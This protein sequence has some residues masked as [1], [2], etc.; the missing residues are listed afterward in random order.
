[1]I[2]PLI[3]SCCV[4]RR[5][6]LRLAAGDEHQPVRAHVPGPLARLLRQADH[7][8]GRQHA[9]N[10]AGSL[11][12][13]IQCVDNTIQYF[14]AGEHDTAGARRWQDHQPERARQALQHRAMLP[15]GRVRLHPEPASRL[16][17]RCARPGLCALR[18]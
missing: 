6:L 16:G 1:M 2:S 8:H 5:V 4:L 15:R 13:P 17:P 14:H 7:A 9:Q 12:F 18:D 11:S 3:R 10:R